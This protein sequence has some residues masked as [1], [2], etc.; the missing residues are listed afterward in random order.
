MCLL[1]H[2]FVRRPPKLGLGGTLPP[3]PHRWSSIGQRK[4]GLAFLLSSGFAFGSTER[5]FSEV[6]RGRGG[7]KRAD[8]NT[9]PHFKFCCL[10]DCLQRLLFCPPPSPP[11]NHSQAQCMQR[12]TKLI[13]AIGENRMQLV[14]AVFLGPLQTSGIQCKWVA[15]VVWSSRAKPESN[16]PS[17]TK[18]PLRQQCL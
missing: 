5:R 3:Q 11:E 16:S 17:K 2:L 18:T 14:F 15:V 8:N 4:G 9:H 1:C 6:R 7:G 13:D 10:L 12:C